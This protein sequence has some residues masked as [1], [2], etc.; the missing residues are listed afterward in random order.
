[1]PASLQTQDYRF[2]LRTLQGVWTWKVR[3]DL[4]QSAPIYQVVDIASPYGLLRDSIPLPGDIVQ[5]MATAIADLKQNFAPVILVDAPGTLTFTVDEGRGF[6]TPQALGI[7]NR[8]VYG[9]LLSVALTSS[10]PWV[11]VSPANLGNLAFNGRATF[12]TTVDSTL[13]LADQSPY[14][15]TIT[16]QDPNIASPQTIPVTVNVRPK[17]AISVTPATLYFL[18]VRPLSGPFDPIPVQQFTIQNIGPSGSSL[19]FFVQKLTGLSDWLT[20][21]TPFEGT[22]AATASQAVR[23]TVQPPQ[24]LQPGVYQEILRV[25][26]YSDNSYRDVIV[27]LIIS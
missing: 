21:F 11:R 15:A 27:Q 22:L 4:S 1:M 5:A 20:G 17:A 26:G 2:N 7:T 18:A 3:V 12:D 14:A 19:D 13:L 25:S 10:A 24:S 6:V 16:V 23:V 9:S 8:G